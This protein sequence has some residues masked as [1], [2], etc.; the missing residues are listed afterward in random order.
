MHNACTMKRYTSKGIDNSNHAVRT[1][2]GRCVSSTRTDGTAQRITVLKLRLWR[3]WNRCRS[4]STPPFSS[5]RMRSAAY[6]TQT[7]SPSASGTAKLHG[8]PDVLARNMVQ[9]AATDGASRLRRCHSANEVRVAFAAA[10]NAWVTAVVTLPVYGC[11]W[12]HRTA[13]CR[14]IATLYWSRFC[15]EGSSPWPRARVLVRTASEFV[16]VNRTTVSLAIC[17]C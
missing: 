5:S 12:R 1:W 10:G 13:S 14:R 7:E 11:M 8:T 17:T 16:V 6:K 3:K 15:R 9:S 4:S 2:P